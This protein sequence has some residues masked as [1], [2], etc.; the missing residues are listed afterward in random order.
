MYFFICEYSEFNKI[1]LVFILIYVD[2]TYHYDYGVTDCE[3]VR[4]QFYQRV[5]KA[6]FI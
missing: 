2:Y 3:T 5:P 6:Y 4:H 1:F